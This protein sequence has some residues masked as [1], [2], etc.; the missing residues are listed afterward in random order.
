MLR[1]WDAYAVYLGMEGGASLWFAMIFAANLIYQVNT[2]GLGPLQLVLVGTVL[3]GTVLLCEVPTGIVADVF[4]RRLSVI[5]GY[6]IMGLGFVLEGLVPRFEAVLL[7][8]VIWGFGYTFT[9][10]AT[11][12]WLADEIGESRAGQ[13]FLRSTQVGQLASVAGL[14][15]GAALGSMQINLPILLGGL[16]ISLIGVWLVAVMPETGFKPKPR[17]ARST[18]QQMAATLRDGLAMVRRRPALSTV[19]VIG[20]VYGTFSEGYDRLWTAHFLQNFTLP[21]WGHAQPI[22]WTTA[23]RVATLLLSTLLIEAVRRR[24]DTDNHRA[25]ARV[26]FV[27]YAL[28]GAAVVGIGLAGNLFAVIALLIGAALVRQLSEPLYMAWVNQ[29]LDPAVRATVLSMSGQ[30][31]ALGQVAGGPVVGMIGDVWGVRAALTVT[32]LLLTPVLG[33]IRFTSERHES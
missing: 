28:L 1:K 12:A 27:I 7:A 29:R 20:A 8:Q 4:S 14:V 30:A 25:V 5:V 10:G 9:S 32:G 21:D 33:L 2:V 24:I 26:L 11:Q 15:L 23:I 13:A 22:A 16:G 18:F 6:L 31:N 17:E 3:E 19:L